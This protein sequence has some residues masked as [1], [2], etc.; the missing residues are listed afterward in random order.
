MSDPT[1]P[2]QSASER[3]NLLLPDQERWPLDISKPV[4]ELQDVSVAFDGKQVLDKLT[5]KILP[6]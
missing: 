3:R 2:P 4:I 6:A 1:P 5:L